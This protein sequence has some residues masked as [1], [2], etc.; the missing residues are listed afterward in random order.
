MKPRL[1]N[2]QGGDIYGCNTNHL[3]TGPFKIQTFLSRFQMGL[4][5]YVA[6][7]NGIQP[8]TL[9]QNIGIICKLTSFWPL[10]IW[11]SLDLRSPLY[12]SSLVLLKVVRLPNVP[13]FRGHLKTD[14]R[15]TLI[16]S[17]FWKADWI[18][19]RK[20]NSL[21]RFWTIGQ[22]SWPDNLNTRHK[23]DWISTIKAAP[24]RVCEITFQF[25]GGR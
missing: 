16:L 13:I 14:R 18:S 7:C 25:R 19:V 3:K 10:E 20:A 1:Y 17:R 12:W 8:S 21:T 9:T 11:T 2:W 24:A 23:K 15:K 5:K 22:I 4:A 6:I